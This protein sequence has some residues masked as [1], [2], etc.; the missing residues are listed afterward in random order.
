MLRSAA[1][2]LY[3]RKALDVMRY[4]LPDDIRLRILRGDRNAERWVT[5]HRANPDVYDKLVEVAR[6]VHAHGSRRVGMKFLYERVRWLS[7]I[8]TVGEKWKLNNTFTAFYARL[9]MFDHPD[10][11]GL[12]ELR[13]SPH[14]R[15]IVD[16]LFEG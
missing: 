5:F 8:E 16:S 10:L 1:P 4:I 12:F 7:E 14:S 13:K 2:R 11:D 3:L 15:Q 9:L 6:F